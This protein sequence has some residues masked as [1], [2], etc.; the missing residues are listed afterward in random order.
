L[1]LVMSILLAQNKTEK[2]FIIGYGIILIFLV[3]S[4]VYLLIPY[5]HREDWKNLTNS[6]D[7]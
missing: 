5:F 1:I 3:C 6:F 2:K 4:L 7:N